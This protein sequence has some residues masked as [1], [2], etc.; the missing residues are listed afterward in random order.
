MIYKDGY[1]FLFYSACGYANKCYSVGVARSK[2]L[3][4][5]FTKFN[6]PIAHTKSP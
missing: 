5:G 1:Y 3:L 4:S 6:F 2:T